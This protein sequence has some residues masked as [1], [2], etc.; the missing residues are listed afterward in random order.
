MSDVQIDYTLLSA[1]YYGIIGEMVRPQSVKV[2]FGFREWALIVDAVYFEP[3]LGTPF[4]VSSVLSPATITRL[5][6]IDTHDVYN[7]ARDQCYTFGR[8]MG[9]SLQEGVDVAVQQ[10]RLRN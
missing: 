1:I 3:E 9:R 6:G 8:D 4:S 7:P 10:A 5:R 2:S